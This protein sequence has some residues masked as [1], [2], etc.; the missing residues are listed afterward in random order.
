MKRQFLY[1][2]VLE[3]ESVII[4]R[5]DSPI[6]DKITLKCWLSLDDTSYDT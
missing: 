3:T 6:K 5:L 4:L 2:Y 1:R